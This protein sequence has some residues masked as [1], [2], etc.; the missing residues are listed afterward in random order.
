VIRAIGATLKSNA[1][2]PAF[3]GEAILLPSE[4]LIADRMDV[5][6]PD[7][8]HAAREAL[9]RRRSA[10]RLRA[11]C[12]AAHGRRRRATT[13]RPAPRASAGCARCARLLAAADRSGGRALAKA[14]FDAPTI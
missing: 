3:K 8:I 4:S 5:V 14:Q 10:R 2:D 9:A 7:A 13:C 12:C 1:L 11:S 6:D